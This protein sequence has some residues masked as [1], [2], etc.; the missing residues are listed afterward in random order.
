MNFYR[1]PIN[2]TK[3]WRVAVIGI[4]VLAVII[5]TFGMYQS[6]NTWAGLS[7]DE[8]YML[9]SAGL[10][11]NTEDGAQERLDTEQKQ[12]VKMFR[13]VGESMTER[14]PE[15]ELKFTGASLGE[16]APSPD[17][18]SKKALNIYYATESVEDQFIAAMVLDNGNGTYELTDNC[19]SIIYQSEYE[20]IL[21]EELDRQGY[22]ITSL[23][24]FLGGMESEFTDVSMSPRE[25]LKTDYDMEGSAVIEIDAS[26]YSSDDMDHAVKNIEAAF[27]NSG[28][29]GTFEI[30]FMKGDEIDRYDCAYSSK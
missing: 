25:L 24:A 26:D 9:T 13:Y 16:Y 4:V 30:H 22:T 19:Y 17:V 12:A 18:E 28:I 7:D 11:E 1:G 29:Y 14:Y 21:R 15:V 20:D 27:K 2:D 6:N 10:V 8:K 3:D 23:T 5:I